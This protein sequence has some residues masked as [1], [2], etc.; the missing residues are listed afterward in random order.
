MHL[1]LQISSRDFDLTPAIE[2]AIRHKAGKLIQFFDRIT[3]CSVVV[4]TPHRHHHKGSLYN[5]RILLAVPGHE[6]VVKR[7][8]HQDLYVAIRDAFVAA[9]RQLKEYSRRRRGDVKYHHET[10]PI[11]PYIAET[12]DDSHMIFYDE[13]SEYRA[14]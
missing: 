1:S 2:Q 12:G 3:G 4:E 13:D 9:S 14:F 5:V 10:T 7:E 8:P 11:S 6:L